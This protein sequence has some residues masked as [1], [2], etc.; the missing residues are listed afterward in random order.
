ME[1]EEREGGR[2]REIERVD[3]PISAEEG[4]YG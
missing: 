4:T 2:E 3:Q 1:T